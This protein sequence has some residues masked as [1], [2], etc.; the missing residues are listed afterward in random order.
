LARPA[1]QGAPQQAW[2]EA[3]RKQAAQ[4]AITGSPPTREHAGSAP[5]GQQLA[6]RETLFAQAGLG[7]QRIASIGKRPDENPGL[8]VGGTPAADSR[9]LSTS[10]CS[11]VGKAPRGR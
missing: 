7:G 6:G 4:A 11:A 3:G 9:A 1:G 10:A 5:E 8:Q 2:R